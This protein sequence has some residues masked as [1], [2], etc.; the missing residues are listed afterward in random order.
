M[1]RGQAAI[2]YFSLF[3]SRP[4]FRGASPFIGVPAGLTRPPFQRTSASG[5]MITFCLFSTPLLGGGCVG[6]PPL[7]QAPSELSLFLAVV[8]P[9]L[10]LGPAINKTPSLR[11]FRCQNWI[12]PLPRPGTESKTVPRAERTLLRSIRRWANLH[13]IDKVQNSSIHF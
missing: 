1:K 3:P 7:L 6:P 9:A 12:P 10:L 2:D 4:L 13:C 8:S 5:P 11:R